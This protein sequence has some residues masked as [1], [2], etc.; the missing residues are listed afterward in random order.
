M[1]QEK[2]IARFCR[3][4]ETVATT[5]NP[6]KSAQYRPAQLSMRRTRQKGSNKAT[7]LATRR[8]K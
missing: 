8:Q 1:Q 5:L 7:E 4:L 2:H 6:G 3:Q